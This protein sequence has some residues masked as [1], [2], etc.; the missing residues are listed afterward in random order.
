MNITALL[1]SQTR[2]PATGP[3]LQALRKKNT[4]PPLVFVQW[5]KVTHL[6]TDDA[7]HTRC[8]RAV[9]APTVL[10]DVDFFT[11]EERPNQPLCKRCK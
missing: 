3:E 6:L 10:G 8:G 4:L 5:G 2:K 1:E 11:F 9:P 7:T